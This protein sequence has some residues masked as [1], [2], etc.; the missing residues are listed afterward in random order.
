MASLPQ[1]T[2]ATDEEIMTLLDHHRLYGL[3]IAYVDAQ[4]PAATKLAPDASLW[5]TDRR[6]AS[7]AERLGCAVDAEAGSAGL[8]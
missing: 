5:T 4:L 6:L 1:A 8:P 7:V 2:V 3:G